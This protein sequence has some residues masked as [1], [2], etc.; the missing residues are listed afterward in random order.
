[1]GRG[2]HGGDFRPQRDERAVE[3]ELRRHHAGPGGEAG[4]DR[5][6]GGRGQQCDVCGGP[7]GGHARPA[8]GSAARGHLSCDQPRG[9][10]LVRFRAGDLSHRRE[11][12]DS[13]AGAVDAISAQGETPAAGDPTEYETAA[14]APMAG[15]AGRLPKH[16]VAETIGIVELPPRDRKS[17][18]EGKRV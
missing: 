8:G 18:V 15:G 7:G 14:T 2:A 16:E 6:G 9:R 5:G 3:E 13:A 4:Y 10:Q 1:M 11:E 12:Y 17:A